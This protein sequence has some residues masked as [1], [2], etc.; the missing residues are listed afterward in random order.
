[1]PNCFKS[2]SPTS[3]YLVLTSDKRKIC[4][5]NVIE[6][7]LLH[8]QLMLA[9]TLE[10]SFLKKG[11][12]IVTYRDYSKFNNIVFREMAGKELDSNSLMKQNFN[13]FDSN[14]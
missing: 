7:G 3:I 8:F 1:M 12:R 13:I 4:N 6:T 14:N 11:P 2:V 10:G 9:A 5:I